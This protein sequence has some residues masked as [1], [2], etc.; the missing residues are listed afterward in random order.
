M[1]F[2]D[3]GKPEVPPKWRIHPMFPEHLLKIGRRWSWKAGQ[4]LNKGTIKW[5]GG[6]YQ[7]GPTRQCRT[8]WLWNWQQDSRCSLS[9][10][11]GNPTYSSRDLIFAHCLEPLPMSSFIAPIRKLTSH[12]GK[13]HL[14]IPLLHRLE[15]TSLGIKGLQCLHLYK[16][17]ACQIP[18]WS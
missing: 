13:L 4:T 9:R 10:T 5:E 14:Q 12:G 17:C 8:M 6:P 15:P 2:R 16:W 3:R 18:S 1:S 7:L 11:T